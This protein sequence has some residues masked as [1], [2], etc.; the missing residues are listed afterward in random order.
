MREP[1]YYTLAALL[2]GPL[3]GYAIMKQVEQLSHGRVR[4]AAGTLYAAL[5]RLAQ[6]ELVEAGRP[7]IVQGRTR[8]YYRLTDQGHHALR[9]E[10]ARMAQAAQLVTGRHR[11]PSIAPELT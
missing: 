4:L 3:H 1:T 2:D 7:E 6:A 10:A 8:R 5:D 9:A 11:R